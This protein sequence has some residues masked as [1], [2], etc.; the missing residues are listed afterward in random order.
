MLY[1]CYP[2]M[3]GNPRWAYIDVL[4]SGCSL[5]LRGPAWAGEM[6]VHWPGV[7]ATFGQGGPHGVLLWAMSPC[8]RVGENRIIVRVSEVYIYIYG[9]HYYYY[10]YYY[11]YYYYYYDDYYYYCY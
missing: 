7:A 8:L 2:D 3:G 1:F 10:Y 11:C 6:E 5:G 9:Y 4:C